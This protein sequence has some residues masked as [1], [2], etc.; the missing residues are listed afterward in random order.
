[1]DNLDKYWSTIKRRLHQ[2]R[3][4]RNFKLLVW[5]LLVLLT[6]LKVFTSLGDSDNGELT[7]SGTKY[8]YKAHRHLL[9]KCG[10]TKLPKSLHSIGDEDL[11]YIYVDQSRKI[12]F[13]AFPGTGI[14]VYS[15]KNRP[16]IKF[17]T[18]PGADREEVLEN[19]K[20][21]ILTFSPY[22]R[23]L[24]FY[25]TV[26]EDYYP[27][28]QRFHKKYDKVIIQKY[29]KNFD[30]KK[31]H[32][33]HDVSFE[34]FVKFIT[35]HAFMETYKNHRWLTIAEVCHPCTIKYN[36]TARYES[37]IDDPVWILQLLG[38]KKLELFE[39]EE[40]VIRKY[41]R[42]LTK[43]SLAEFHKRFIDDFTLFNYKMMEL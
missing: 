8:Q 11:D 14:S 22:A 27:W 39:T 40:K 19:Y 21:I 7:E 35:D 34:E 33:M 9:E 36:I 10:E 37:L 2:L 42:N 43:N 29:R 24:S 15:L 1:M 6:V 3:L 4:Y 38:I 13:C 41:F 28:N 32:K 26:F 20:K 12:L 18:L 23:L 17:S 16:V 30:E 31:L 5:I 25:R